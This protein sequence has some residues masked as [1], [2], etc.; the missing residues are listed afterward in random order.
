MNQ[1]VQQLFKSL[2]SKCWISNVYKKHWWMN[3]TL[4]A[5]H[6]SKKPQNQI[7]NTCNSLSQYF[8][9]VRGSCIIWIEFPEW[10]YVYSVLAI[11]KQHSP[12]GV[13]YPSIS[14]PKFYDYFHLFLYRIV[15][16]WINSNTSIST[17]G[18]PSRPPTTSFTPQ[19]FHNNHYIQF[20]LL[21]KSI[22]SFFIFNYFIHSLVRFVVFCIS[23]KSKWIIGS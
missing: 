6:N 22:W 17:T 8:I 18:P 2:L 7:I 14:K 5:K 10:K 15:W 13:I 23:L 12:T 3:N 19:A 21:F 20:N 9:W 1:G 16:S 11:S 4:Y